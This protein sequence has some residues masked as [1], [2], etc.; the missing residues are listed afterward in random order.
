MQH[1][2]GVS[3]AKILQATQIK[4]NEDVDEKAGTSKSAQ[5]M[6]VDSDVLNVPLCYSLLNLK[7]VWSLPDPKESDMP[8]FIATCHALQLLGSL[9]RHTQYSSCTCILEIWKKFV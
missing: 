7:E 4:Q 2:S 9:F 1:R 3:N 5:P 6:D 8:S